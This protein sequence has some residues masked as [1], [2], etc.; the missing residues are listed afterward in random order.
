MSLNL[1]KVSF[2]HLVNKDNP[3][4]SS[5]LICYLR[6]SKKILKGICKYIAKCEINPFIQ[7]TLLDQDEL[8]SLQ[9][10]KVT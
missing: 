8:S 1:S 6:T 4:L 2:I 10:S 3:C 9:L 7:Q 5:F